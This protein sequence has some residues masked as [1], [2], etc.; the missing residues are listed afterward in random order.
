MSDTI[1]SLSDY[2]VA[3]TILLIGVADS[4]DELIQGH[5]SIERALVQVPMPRMSDGEVKEIVVKGLSRLQ[6][7]IEPDSLDE[8]IALSQ[9][10][11]Y[12]THLLALHTARAALE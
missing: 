1:K 11:P 6:M 5:Q 4:V 7:G 10:L 9:G 3:T 8:L 2:A 12:I